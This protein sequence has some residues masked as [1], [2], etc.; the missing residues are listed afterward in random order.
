MRTYTDVWRVKLGGVD[1]VDH[2]IGRKESQSV[3]IVLKVFNVAENVLKITSVVTSPR[4]VTI[5]RH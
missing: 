3:G 2:L 4:S 5:Q 1:I